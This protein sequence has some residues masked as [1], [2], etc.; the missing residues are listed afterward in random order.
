MCAHINE[1]YCLTNTKVGAQKLAREV[2]F[3][4]NI[5]VHVHVCTILTVYFQPGA[6]LQTA[7]QKPGS[8]TWMASITAGWFR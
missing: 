2:T 1:N 3:V 4:Q 8:L 6:V 7:Q 5:R